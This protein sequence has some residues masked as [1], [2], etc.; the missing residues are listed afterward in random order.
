MHPDRDQPVVDRQLGQRAVKIANR[1]NPQHLGDLV[2]GDAQTGCFL[3][4][5]NNL[6]FRP[7]QCPF[8]PDL[9]QKRLTAQRRLKPGH[10][11]IQVGLVVRQDRESQVAV[12]PVAQL[13]GPQIRD[14][15]HVFKD[16][17]LDLILRPG[18][19]MRLN[20]GDILADQRQTLQNL[21]DPA[22]KR[23]V[24]FIKDDR[25]RGAPDIPAASG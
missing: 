17:G 25:H 15:R 7:G 21:G 20:L 13:E 14:T 6:Q 1:G 4:T 12:A 19:S 22:F 9:R 18:P 5:R 23:M 16:F 8:G 10:G 3:D 11:D 24:K 2:G